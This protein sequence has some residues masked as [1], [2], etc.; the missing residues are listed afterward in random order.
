MELR[1]QF[2]KLRREKHMTQQTLSNISGVSGDIISRFERGVSNISINK[3]E[4]LCTSMDI[5]PVL[6]DK[7]QLKSLSE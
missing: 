4:T 6:F 5:S 1:V 7:D 3:F 2:K